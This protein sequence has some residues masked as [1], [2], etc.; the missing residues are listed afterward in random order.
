MRFLDANTS[1]QIT[2]GEEMPG[3]V[4]YFLGENPSN[5]HT[6][7]P[8]YASIKY[9]NLYPGIDLKYGG[10]I[11]QLKGTYVVAAGADPS[12]I[13]WRYEGV[14]SISVDANGNL[15]VRLTSSDPST[16]AGDVATSQPLIITEQA[17]LAWQE[18][19]GQKREVGARFSIAQDGS[20]AFALND[21]DSA[22]PLIIDPYITF[23]TYLG[24][25]G[26]DAGFGVALDTSGNIY[27]AGLAEST[28]FP[29]RNPYDP[30]LGDNCAAS[31]Y[32]P[33][34]LKGLHANIRS[35]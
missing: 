32:S 10:T 5:W 18:I 8:T 9:T 24:G 27:V 12:S 20:I 13:K 31:V 17:P 35:D 1:P 19:A 7:V 22:Y 6:N 15:Q 23:G 25:I 28:N 33:V 30:S 14:D 3:K 11:G 34:Y 2:S 4:N 21:Y 26:S 29:I 16:N